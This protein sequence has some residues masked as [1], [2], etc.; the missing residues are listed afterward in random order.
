MESKRFFLS[1]L[2]CLM[3]SFYSFAQDPGDPTSEDPG[4][5][6]TVPVNQIEG[7][8][9]LTALVS[10]YFCLKKVKNTY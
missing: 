7:L 4:D 10:G 8:L 9:V 1:T 3:F 6:Q 5:V 2:M